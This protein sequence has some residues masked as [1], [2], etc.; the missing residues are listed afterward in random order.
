MPTK[1][2]DDEVWSDV[3]QKTVDT[4]VHCKLMIKETDV[5]QVLIRKGL[6][7]I[8]LDELTEYA[9]QKSEKRGNL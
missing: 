6:E 8:T 4:I 5:L 1:H 3:I 7:T 2:V 9:K